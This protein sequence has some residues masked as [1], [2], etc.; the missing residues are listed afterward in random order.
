MRD[1]LWNDRVNSWSR[2]RLQNQTVWE[3]CLG[4]CIETRTLQCKSGECEHGQRFRGHQPRQQVPAGPGSKPPAPRAVRNQP[5]GVAAP[6]RP[7]H[8]SAPC[9]LSGGAAPPPLP[10]APGS[11]RGRGLPDASRAS[12]VREG[13]A[14]LGA[15]HVRGGPTARRGAESSDAPGRRGLGGRGSRGLR[16]AV[17]G[18]SRPAPPSGGGGLQPHV[19]RPG[20]PD[21]HVRD[22]AAGPPQNG[23]LRGAGRTREPP[24]APGL[25]ACGGASPQGS[26]LLSHPRGGGWSAPDGR[27]ACVLAGRGCGS[28]RVGLR[29]SDAPGKAR[30][31]RC[32]EPRRAAPMPLCAPAAAS[33][34]L[35]DSR[36][37]SVPPSPAISATDWGIGGPSRPSFPR[38]RL[39]VLPLGLVVILVRR[40]PLSKPQAWSFFFVFVFF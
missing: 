11:L 19:A 4:I 15:P 32:A 33:R 23:A 28:A 39:W 24:R 2:V 12:R 10:R 22:E 38:V 13:G 29:R 21:A 30:D 7:A 16:V 14:A 20:F 3:H 27:R 25:T 36:R 34:P 26:L 9:S 6:P 40:E 37:V 18:D 17:P 31:L 8:R 5:V 1:G 35:R